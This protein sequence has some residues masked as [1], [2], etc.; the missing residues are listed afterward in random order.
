MITGHQITAARG[1][2]GW[3]Q[4]DLGVRIGVSRPSVSTWE[5]GMRIPKDRVPDL[6]KIFEK[7]NIEFINS[8]G[9]VGVI[10]RRIGHNNKA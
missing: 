6:L 10:L 5:A 3:L 7:E 8:A 1:L 2:L 9:E 4:G